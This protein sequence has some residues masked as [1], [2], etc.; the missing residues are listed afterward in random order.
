VADTSI[1]S[2]RTAV[3]RGPRLTVRPWQPGDAAA[4]HAAM[5][6][7]AMHRFLSLPDPYTAD[8][9]REFVASSGDP[10]NPEIGF[11]LLETASGDVVGSIGLRPGTLGPHRRR[12]GL[13]YAVYPDAQGNGYAAEA[14]EIVTAAAFDAGAARVDLECAVDNIASAKTALA[15]GFRFEGIERYALRLHDDVV[16]AASFAR[17]SADPRGRVPRAFAAL[18]VTG[19]GDGVIR[20]RELDESDAG[21][22][23]DQEADPLTVSTGFTGE[24]PAVEDTLARCRRAHLE[25]L[26]GGLAQFAIVDEQSGRF[27]GSL[28]VRKP[29]PPDVGGIGY[30][31]HPAFRGRGYAAR[32]LRLVTAWAF[33]TAGFARLELGAKDD[34][35]A[36]QRAALSGGFAPDG[37]RAARL[38]RPDGSFADEVRFAAVNPQTLRRISP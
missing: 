23:Q 4:V 10:R 7:R 21:S 29:G 9:A 36:S 22:Y 8:D 31:V 28:Q 18:P 19:L 34:N 35:V 27:A 6:H 37:V 32:A 16:D 14:V 3:L 33:G 1:E 11:A 25:W 2:L 5:Q 12:A 13:G 17:L 15:A 30:T 26:V 24:A 20:M 38:R